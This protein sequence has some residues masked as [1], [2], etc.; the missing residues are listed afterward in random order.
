MRD[1]LVT[2][3]GQNHNQFHVKWVTG[4][5]NSGVNMAIVTSQVKEEAEIMFAEAYTW[6]YVRP[7]R[8]WRMNSV[9]WWAP[10]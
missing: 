4:R 6:F 3:Y 2:R 1:A 8:S 5:S 10:R 7:D 9:R